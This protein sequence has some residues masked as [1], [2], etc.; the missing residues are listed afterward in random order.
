[1]RIDSSGRVGIG[2]EPASDSVL[3]VRGADTNNKYIRTIN[4]NG[5]AYFGTIADGTGVI[6][7]NTSLK[8]TTGSSFTERMRIDS[9]GRLG[10]GTTSPSYKLQVNGTAYINE[11]LYV[12]GA[13]TIDDNLY[14]T[15]GNVGIGGAS[16]TAYSGYS[17][18]ALNGTNGGLLEFKKGDVQQSY[19]TNA[20]DPLLQF[21]TNAY[22][23]WLCFTMG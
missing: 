23:F 2:G 15:S 6:E 17:T 4:N 14:V 19:I 5:T 10:I 21:V 1:M 16:P 11:T 22:R 12:N 18:L 7:S 8:F 13:T 9:S 3:T 20:G